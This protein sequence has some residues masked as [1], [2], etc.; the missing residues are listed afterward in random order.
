M[1]PVNQ[2]CSSARPIQLKHIGAVLKHIGAVRSIG[3]KPCKAM[4]GFV[5]K[6]SATSGNLADDT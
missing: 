5:Q 2:G 3:A 1:Q 4:I 6:L